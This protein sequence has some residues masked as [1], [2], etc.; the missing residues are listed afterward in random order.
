MKPIFDNGHGGVIDGVYQTPG[1]RSPN[2][3]HGVLYEGEFNRWIVDELIN[4]CNIYGLDY[5][6]ASPELE[7]VSLKERVRRAN[8][9]HKSDDQVYFLSIHANAGGGTGIEGFTSKGIT[10][11]DEIAEAFLEN[12]ENDL[13]CIMKM[14]FDEGDGDHDKEENFFVLRKTT[15]PAFLLECGFMDHRDDYEKLW[16]K[17][18]RTQLCDS[19]FRTIKELY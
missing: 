17:E 13:E 12:I 1:K 5:Y 14:R 15:C 11:S 8:A 18:Y 3:N 9:L 4:R 2:W 7:D 19:I 6:H 10:K 16:S